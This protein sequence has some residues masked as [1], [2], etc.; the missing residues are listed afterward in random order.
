MVNALIVCISR[1]R[2][3]ANLARSHIR[4]DIVSWI[5]GKPGRFRSEES[6]ESTFGYTLRPQA[7][8]LAEW[9]RVKFSDNRF[10]AKLYQDAKAKTGYLEI[11]TG[12]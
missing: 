2:V 5:A 4:A 3:E 6:A 7:D 10:S 9:L 12:R 8:N 1:P 11:W